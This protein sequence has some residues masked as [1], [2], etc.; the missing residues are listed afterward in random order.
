MIEIVA[1]EVGV[2]IDNELSGHALSPR[3]DQLGLMSLG[4][5]DL[6]HIGAVDFFEGQESRGHAAAGRHELPAAEA[7][8]LAV[9]VGQFEDPPLDAFLRLALSGRQILAVGNNLRRYRGRGRSLF[10]SRDKTLFSFAQPAAHCILPN[11][12]GC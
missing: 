2:H 10:G 5:V 1:D 12:Y 11:F 8:L 9:L 7:Q 6:E 4:S 3:H